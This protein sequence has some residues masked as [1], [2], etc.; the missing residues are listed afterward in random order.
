MGAKL[1]IDLAKCK[2]QGQSGVQ[3]SYKHHP[4]NKGIDVL[5]EEIRFSLICRRCE[6][7][8]CVKVCP[9]KAL[10]KIKTEGAKEGVLKRAALLCTGCGTCTMACPFGTIYP[11]LIPFVGSVC[12]L[13]ISRLAPD[14]RPLCAETCRDGS[15]EYGEVAAS[16]EWVELR[17]HLVARVLPGSRWVPCLREKAPR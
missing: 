6:S 15:I 14:Q 11:D 16:G 7:A 9:Q 17:P 10:E 1:T 5:L 3:C 12:D 8:P 2:P 4:Q 13:C